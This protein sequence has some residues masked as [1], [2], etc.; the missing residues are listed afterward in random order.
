MR[1]LP[2]VSSDDVVKVPKKEGFEDAPKRGKGRHTAFYKI[3]ETG[4][5]LLVIVPKR[6]R[7]PTGTMMAILKQADLSKERFIKLLK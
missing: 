6:E 4:H 2:L 7:L 3:D 5:K 1:K